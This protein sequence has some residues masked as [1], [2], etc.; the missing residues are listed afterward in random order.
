MIGFCVCVCK[1]SVMVVITLCSDV[2]KTGRS[3]LK[4]WFLCI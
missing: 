1:G 4:V 3:L 2:D